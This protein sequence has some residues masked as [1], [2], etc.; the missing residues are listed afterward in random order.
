MTL[1]SFGQK[2]KAIIVVLRGGG[3]KPRLKKINQELSAEGARVVRPLSKRVSLLSRSREVARE[4]LEH[5]SVVSGGLDVRL[6]AHGIDT[7]ARHADIPAQKLQNRKATDILHADCM[8]RHAQRVHKDG[9][10]D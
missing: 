3:S 4:V 1:S 8:L 9:G 7:A 10:L 5:D 6:P 2:S